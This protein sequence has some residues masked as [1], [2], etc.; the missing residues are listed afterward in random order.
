M[1]HCTQCGGPIDAK[2]KSCPSCGEPNLFVEGKQVAHDAP[3]KKNSRIL[4]FGGSLVVAILLAIYGALHLE[5][6]DPAT[7]LE[8]ARTAL[9]DWFSEKPAVSSPQKKAHAPAARRAKKASALAVD[10]KGY[11]RLSG[12]LGDIMKVRAEFATEDAVFGGK[13]SLRVVVKIDKGYMRAIYPKYPDQSVHG[14]MAIF[15]DDQV[16]CAGV[17]GDGS[18]YW[19]L[20]T[21]KKPATL[22]AANG[23]SIGQ[24]RTA[25]GDFFYVESSGVNR[26]IYRLKLQKS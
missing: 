19:G 6:M 7:V 18:H 17:F 24:Y 9:P 10:E 13:G 1:M 26:V 20:C 11:V 8:L 25:P 4:I 16:R 14:E 21:G 12:A 5:V 22:E 15:G 3:G 23:P 2:A